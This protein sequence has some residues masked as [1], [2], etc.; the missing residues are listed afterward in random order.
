MTFIS[1]VASGAA[2]AVVRGSAAWPSPVGTIALATRHPIKTSCFTNNWILTISSS[3]V[4][5]CRAL[6]GASCRARSLKRSCRLT[7]SR[8]PIVSLCALPMGKRRPNSSCGVRRAQVYPIC[9]KETGQS[10]KK[11]WRPGNQTRRKEKRTGCARDGT[12][13]VTH[14]AIHSPYEPHRRESMHE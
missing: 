5:M 2:D 12:V 3:S 11:R 6:D 13:G 10:F 1:P 8:F 7:R 14:T 9:R 4:G